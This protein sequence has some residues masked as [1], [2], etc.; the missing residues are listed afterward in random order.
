M[1]GG[2]H[3]EQVRKTSHSHT[4]FASWARCSSKGGLALHKKSALLSFPVSDPFFVWRIDKRWWRD[5]YKDLHHVHNV[6]DGVY[7]CSNA[8]LWQHSTIKCMTIDDPMWPPAQIVYGDKIYTILF[9]LHYINL[10]NN[11]SKNPSSRLIFF[12]IKSIRRKKNPSFR[13]PVNLIGDGPLKE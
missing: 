4:L 1:E 11:S 6:Q 7:F 12:L 3:A 10:Y 9:S 8:I 13:S 2:R 5:C